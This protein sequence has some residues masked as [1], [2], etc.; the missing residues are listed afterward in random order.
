M[1]EDKNTT[2][3]LKDFTFTPPENND[4]IIKTPNKNGEL[5]TEVIETKTKTTSEANKT[6]SPKMTLQESAATK[7]LE[8]TSDFLYTM[9]AGVM[10]R[11]PDLNFTSIS[12][13][14]NTIAWYSGAL[15][16]DIVTTLFGYGAVNTVAKGLTGVKWISKAGQVINKAPFLAEGLKGATAGAV[17]SGIDK[18]IRPDVGVYETS[19]MMAELGG[20]DAAREI[21]NIALRKLPINP[22]LKEVLA[23]TAD[24]VGGGLTALTIH[25][26]VDDFAKEVI[27]PEAVAMG[28]VDVLL[29]AAAKG[30]AKIDIEELKGIKDDLE[31]GHLNPDTAMMK[32]NEL[33]GDQKIDIEKL[34]ADLAADAELARQKFKESIEMMEKLKQQT[35]EPP[36]GSKEYFKKTEEELKEGIAKEEAELNKPSEELQ[37]TEQPK[38]STE[39]KQPEEYK[40]INED[41]VRE[42]VKKI[43]TKASEAKEVKPPK[44]PINTKH[45]KADDEIVANV[46]KMGEVIEQ[47]KGKDILTDAELK[48]RVEQRFENKDKFYKDIMDAYGVDLKNA[49]DLAEL[50]LKSPEEALTYRRIM[51]DLANKT[52]Y[53]AKLLLEKVK[54]GEEITANDKVEFLKLLDMYATMTEKVKDIAK[55]AGRLLRSFQADAEGVYKDPLQMTWDELNK[56]VDAQALLNA[57][58][59]VDVKEFQSLLDDIAKADSI[60]DV[61]RATKKHRAADLLDLIIEYRTANLLTNPNTHLRNFISQTSHQIWDLAVDWIGAIGGIAMKSEDKLTFKQALAKTV[62]VFEGIARG[63]Y[64]PVVTMKDVYGITHGKETVS[65]KDLF[66]LFIT[67]PKRYYKIMQATQLEKPRTSLEHMGGID[68]ESIYGQPNKSYVRVLTEAVNRGL[69]ILKTLSFGGLKLTDQPFSHAGYFSELRKAVERDI[70]LGKIDRAEAKT[71]MKTVEDYRAVKVYM[72]LIQRTFVRDTGKSVE[73][74]FRFAKIFLERKG[75]SPDAIRFVEAELKN[76]E[77]K[78]EY[79][80]MV[81]DYDRMAYKKATEMT[82][83]DDLDWAITKAGE[84]AVNEFR[85]LRLISPFFHTPAKL[86]E[87]G[88]RAAGVTPYYWKKLFFSN[89]PREKQRALGALTVAGMMWYLGVSKY[90]NRELTPTY[91]DAEERRRFEEAGLPENA[92]KIGDR[93]WNVQQL[94][95]EVSVLLTTA[96]NLARA[97][98]EL[99]DKNDERTWN[100]KVS[101][102]IIIL[103]NILLNKT[104]AKPASEFLDALMGR[105]AERF[106]INF[107]SSFKPFR[108]FGVFK[109]QQCSKY[110]KDYT[111]EYMK[112]YW[113]LDEFGEYREQWD[114]IFGLRTSTAEKGKKSP[115]R[116]EKIRLQLNFPIMGKQ[117]YGIELTDKQY[118]TLQRLLSSEDG[119]NLEGELNK[120]IESPIYKMAGDDYRRYLILDKVREIQNKAKDTFAREQLGIDTVVQ[121]E[122]QKKQELF[123]PEVDMSNDWFK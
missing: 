66:M 48:Q 2:S 43:P 7:G 44:G 72:P 73:E 45:I 60:A 40:P 119:F 64:K 34:K 70:E 85:L 4:L 61:T 115:I 107:A 22:V 86:I 123:S 49:Q 67:D 30:H 69:G 77:L 55:G 11:K 62:G 28:I 118:T 58:D 6:I 111:G 113:R 16:W 100:E 84:K 89:N 24:V 121:T 3:D 114:Y 31:T 8:K 9:A 94:E 92:I 68:L 110:M 93:W 15:G 59:D 74:S 81:E 33:V 21:T 18:I 47:I 32:V 41:V 91:R 37:Q 83:K 105:G 1:A 75:Y 99:K 120:L 82:F 26:K 117:L 35:K 106:T 12:P 108:G 79:F 27:A 80:Q 42:F 13:T 122:I 109:E 53:N 10:G 101:G 102:F 39:A 38:K 63:F 52:Q 5:E 116:Q 112:G 20:G 65:V 36:K 14:A 17:K 98:E 54:N 56:S 78:D 29:F 76:V 19:I 97:S 96:A 23:Y 104:W 88:L 46:L 51:V 103:S 25:G 87:D 50:L 90:I 57:V 95:P 71:I